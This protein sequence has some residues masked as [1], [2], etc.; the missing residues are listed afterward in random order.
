VIDLKDF[1]SAK[2]EYV[3]EDGKPYAIRNGKRFEVVCE[4]DLVLPK[5]KRKEFKPEFVK[6]PMRWVEVLEQAK[7]LSAYR[8]ALRILLEKFQ[9]ERTGGE[10][11]L[12]AEKTRMSSANRHR[13]A[14]E[15][16]QLGLIRLSRKGKYTLRVILL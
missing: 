8:L 4:P 7:S 14:K 1:E 3:E 15:L 5:A 2:I 13:A 12:S 9:R 16:E 6:V 11:V 10:I